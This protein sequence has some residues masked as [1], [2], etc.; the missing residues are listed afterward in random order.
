[1]LARGQQDA[2]RGQWRQQGNRHRDTGNGAGFLAGD[3]VGTGRS[4]CQGNKKVV[5]IGKS[6][7]STYNRE[8]RKWRKK[9]AQ[10]KRFKY[11]GKG[12]PF[13]ARK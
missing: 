9:P 3:S 10:R 4:R 6:Y 1:M 11:G 12:S 7:K 2:R 8:Y 5:K 13:M